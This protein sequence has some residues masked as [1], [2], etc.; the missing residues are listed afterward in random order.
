M[1]GLEAL[2]AGLPVVVG[3]NSGFGEALCSIPFGSSFVVNSED[4][5]DN[6]V[7]PY[8]NSG[9][10]RTEKFDLMK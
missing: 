8:R 4:P 1:T 3:H 7:R 10:A 5:A 9:T 2:S 6:G